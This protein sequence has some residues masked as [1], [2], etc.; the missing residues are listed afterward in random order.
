MAS[1]DKPYRL[2]PPIVVADMCLASAWRDEVDDESRL[3][4]EMSSDTIHAMKKRENV[5]NYQL[6][7]QHELIC[8]LRERCVR[9]ARSLEQAECGK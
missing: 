3:L 8:E 2:P 6:K 7:A 4:H 5:L 1:E 9:L